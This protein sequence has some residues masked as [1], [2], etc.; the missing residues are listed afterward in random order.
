M[1]RKG[2]EEEEGREGKGEKERKGNFF[3]SVFSFS[4]L[5]SFFESS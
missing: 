3:K 2:E 4:F 5:L 1:K